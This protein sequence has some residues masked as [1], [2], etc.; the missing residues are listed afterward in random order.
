MTA[1]PPRRH[2]L[3]GFDI[4]LDEQLRAWLIEVNI[5]PRC[6]PPGG[7]GRAGGRRADAGGA[8]RSMASSSPLDRAI[9]GA[10][11]R[12]VFNAAGFL[13]PTRRGPVDATPWRGRPLTAE[14]RA[15]HAL[16]VTTAADV[17]AA[18]ALPRLLAELTDDD[19]A[20]LLE[21]EDE[22]ARAGP[23]LAR[24]FPSAD[25]QYL[26]YTETPRYYNLL[27]TAWAQHW[28]AAAPDAGRGPGHRR[29]AAGETN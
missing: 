21:S 14:E 22:R 26:L 7:V 9:K 2:E 13:P 20:V 3:Y 8:G 6:G 27:L 19:V 4:M 29:R 16:F 5:S 25:P 18:G 1:G 10:L 24:V 28:A 15:K 17:L 11:L 23:A 12:D